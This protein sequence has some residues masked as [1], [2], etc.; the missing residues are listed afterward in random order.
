MVGSWIQGPLCPGKPQGR[1]KHG[2]RADSHSDSTIHK[3][4]P[5]PKGSKEQFSGMVTAGNVR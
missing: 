4:G 5:E 1:T 2:D 3:L